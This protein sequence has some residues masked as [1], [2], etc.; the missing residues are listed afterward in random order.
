MLQRLAIHDKVVQEN[1]NECR[2]ILV[3][4]LSDDAL[5]RGRCRFHSEHHYLGHEDTPFRDK[6]RFLLIF[7]VHS[8]LVIAAEPI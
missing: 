1:L 8:D 6:H 3:E 5:E 4:N 7:R 2:D